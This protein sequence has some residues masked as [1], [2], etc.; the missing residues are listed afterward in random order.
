MPWIK[1]KVTGV[2]WE[3]TREDTLR[4]LAK[5]PDYEEVED[6]TAEKLEEKKKP[7]SDKKNA[8]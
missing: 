6:P 5:D 2:V 1:N 7:A 4:D 3:I 8:E